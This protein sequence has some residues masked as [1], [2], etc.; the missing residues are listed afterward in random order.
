MPLSLK[1]NKALAILYL[2]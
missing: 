2:K 1:Y